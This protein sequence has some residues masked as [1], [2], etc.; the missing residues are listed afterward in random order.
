MATE[1]IQ[2]FETKESL[3]EAEVLV[4]FDTIRASIPRGQTL[5]SWKGMV[6]IQFACLP[7]LKK[8]VF[9]LNAP[10]RP[11]FRIEITS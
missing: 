11:S 8:P 10:G 4:A 9:P 1:V 2:H 3:T 6:R 7:R 5:K